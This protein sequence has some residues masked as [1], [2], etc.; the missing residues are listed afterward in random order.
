M[1][2]CGKYN[3]ASC[4]HLLRAIPNIDVI[5]IGSRESVGDSWMETAIGPKS[6][7]TC[8][9]FHFPL[10]QRNGFLCGNGVPLFFICFEYVVLL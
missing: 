1:F 4:V 10:S 9:M 6:R 8:Q 7:S 2:F 5:L 3:E